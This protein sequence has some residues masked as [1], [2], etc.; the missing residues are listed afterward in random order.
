MKRTVDEKVKYN[1]GQKTPFSW[2][3]LWGVRA[4]R[5]YPKANAAEK[6]RLLA[7]MDDYRNTA[8]NGKGK[9]RECGKGYMCALRDCANERKGK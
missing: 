2:G 4:Y 1:Y 8:V 3:Y 6:K 5:R 7:E 9:S